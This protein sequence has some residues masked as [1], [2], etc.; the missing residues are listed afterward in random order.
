AIGNYRLHHENKLLI[1]N[2]IL[3]VHK[4]KDKPVYKNT[5]QLVNKIK[6]MER[7]NSDIS[8]EKIIQL[9]GGSVTNSISQICKM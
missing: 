1:S 8:D 9:L 7:S 2:K 3:K 6:E 4:I 5:L